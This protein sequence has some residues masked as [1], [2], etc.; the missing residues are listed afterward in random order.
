[1]DLTYG[2]IGFA[3]AH[4][5]AVA[6]P[7]PSFVLV[8]Q[9]AASRS[10]AAA[11]VATAALTLGAAL[12]AAAALFGLQSLFKHA[13]WLYLA[14]R[15]GGGL[16]LLWL[17]YQ[18][19]RHAG[20]GDLAAPAGGEPAA[21]DM[22]GIFWKALLVQLSNPKVIVFFSGIMA[23][24]LPRDLSPQAAAIVVMVVAFNEFVWYALVSLLFSGGRAR[25]IYRGARAWIERL[26]G[27]VLAVLGLRLALD[28]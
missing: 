19:I 9:V 11:L 8:A 14:L 24:L 18:L 22:R 16:Y 20:S 17:G 21:A 25:R 6:S 23:A 2:L 12:W 5:L 28:R 15:I 4:M 1:M 26:T 3:I 13:D 10:R 27:G 7:G